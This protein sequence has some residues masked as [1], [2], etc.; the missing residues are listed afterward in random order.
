MFIVLTVDIYSH[1]VFFPVIIIF[2][3][4]LYLSYTFSLP[5]FASHILTLS[6]FP[7]LCFFFL[8]FTLFLFPP[9][10]FSNLFHFLPLSLF[11]L[12]IIHTLSLSLS[13]FL[14]S[15]YFLSISFTLSF[16]LSV[17][18]SFYHSH[19]FSLSLFLSPPHFTFSSSLSLCFSFYLSLLFLSFEWRHEC[20]SIC[21]TGGIMVIS[22]ENLISDLY[23]TSG[24]G[25]LH[26]LCTSNLKK[27]M[28]PSLPLLVMGKMIG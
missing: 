15:P 21:T 23:S 20:I 8:S 28:S 4:S 14:S 2:F 16:F 25:C 6:F 9:L 13:L 1:S 7:S 22:V 26:S 18:F 27:G 10:C 12:F 5:I 3:F 24:Q 19:A 11:F 17:L